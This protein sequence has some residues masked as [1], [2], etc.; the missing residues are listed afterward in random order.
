MLKMIIPA[1]ATAIA[2]NAT[3]TALAQSH[4]ADSRSMTCNEARTVVMRHGAIVLSTGQHTY[5]RYVAHERFCSPHQMAER[6]AVPS[7]DA[8]AC[9]VGYRCVLDTRREDRRW[10]LHRR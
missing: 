7:R 5:D 4:R 1:V 6:A 9:F 2:L 8:A 10:W 3:S